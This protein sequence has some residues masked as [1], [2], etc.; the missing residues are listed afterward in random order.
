MEGKLISL[1]ERLKQENEPK[2]TR[3]GGKLFQRFITRSAKKLDLTELLQK[4]LKILYRCPLLELDPFLCTGV[5]T[6]F[7]HSSDIQLTDRS[8][9]N[10]SAKG[11]VIA[12][13]TRLNSNR[14][15][16]SGPADRL[17]FSLLI[18]ASTSC[19]L[20]LIEDSEETF[21]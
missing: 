16:P 7:F 8:C 2:L 1:T 10:T 5:I 14:G 12:C 4:C 3:S 9:L 20:K 13:L 11:P 21:S 18:A 6:S 19:S 17:L 15:N